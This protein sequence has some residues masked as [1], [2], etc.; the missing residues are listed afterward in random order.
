[1]IYNASE[2]EQ[3][4][5][6][7]VAAMMCAAAR[8]APKTKGIDNIITVIVTG[9]DL[10]ALS[11][12][13]IE[14]GLREFGTTETHFTRDAMNVRNSKAVVLIGVKRSH[15]GLPYCSLCGFEN[16]DACSKSG[17]SCVF[18]PIDLGIALGSAVSVSAD[19]RI[20]NRIMFSV[21]KAAEEMGYAEEAVI[22]QGVPL[23]ASG[24]NIYFDRKPSSAKKS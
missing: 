9:D 5:V 21:G 7:D 10:N 8:T 13:M 4:A 1:M 18:S 23:N 14:V 22:W 3:K 20:D 2:S 24:K 16:C 6:L 19:H 17:A 15:Y 11:D 12:K